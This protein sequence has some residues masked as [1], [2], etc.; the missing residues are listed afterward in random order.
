MCTL[1]TV[2][3]LWRREIYRSTRKRNKSVK[4]DQ[5]TMPEA[6]KILKIS[7]SHSHKHTCAPA[8]ILYLILMNLMNELMNHRQVS[9]SFTA[10]GFKTQTVRW[11]NVY[12]GDTV[13][14]QKM[15]YC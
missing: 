2:Q 8:Y 3:V 4:S 13:E 1:Q 6:Y 14:E 12:C 9:H 11:Y 5:T 7:Q 10:F 15:K